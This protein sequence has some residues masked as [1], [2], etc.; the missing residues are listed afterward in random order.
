MRYVRIE[1][2]KEGMV[3]CK[4]LFGKNNEILLN[5]GVIIR[6]SYISK[7]KELG[8]HGIYIEDS[9]SEDTPTVLIDDNLRIECVKSVRKL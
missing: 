1:D 3:N 2:L 4:P 8:Y 6:E 7:L 5:S 9:I